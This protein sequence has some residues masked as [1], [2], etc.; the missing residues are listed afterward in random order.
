MR[1]SVVI[2]TCLVAASVAFAAEGG[3]VRIPRVDRP[4][5]LSDFIEGRAR[6]AEAVVSDFRQMMPGDG[7]PATQQTTAYLSYDDDNLYVAFYCKDDPAL[8]R[9]RYAK[10]DQ[11]MTDDRITFALDTFHDHHRAY[12]FDVN[13]F[14]IQADGNVTDGVEDDPSWDTIW[15]AEGKMTADGYVTL[16]AIPFKSLRFP[17]AEEQTWG[18]ILGRWINRNNEFSL[19]PTISRS[20]PGWVQQGGDLEGIRKISSGRN[21]QVIPYGSLRSSKSLDT[22]AGRFDRSREFR[23]GMDGKAVIKDAFTL[24]VALNPDFSQ[25]ESD[26]P[27]VTVNQ[28]YEVFFP[29]KRPFFLENAGFFKTPQTLLFSRRIADPEFGARLTGKVGRWAIGLLAADDRAPG[30]RVAPEDELHGEKAM[31]GVLRIQ[32][33]FLRD[34]GAAVMVTSQDFG[35]THNRVASFDTRLRVLPNWI[36]TG[37]AMTSSTRLRDGTRL[38]GPAYYSEFAHSGLHFVSSTTY[39]DRSPQFRADLGFINRVDM[40]EAAHT[41]GYIWRPEGKAIVSFGPR[42]KGS[43]NYDRLGRLQDWSVSP[44]FDLE[45]PRFTTIK[46]NQW[47]GFELFADQGFRKRHTEITF[48]SDWQRWLALTGEFQ[49]GTAVNYYP[50]AGLRPSIA[51]STGAQAGFTLRPNAHWKLDETYLYSELATPSDGIFNNHIIRSKANYQFNKAASLRAILDYN[52]VLP[53]AALVN[54]DREKHVGAD[55]LLTYML[56]PGTALYVGYT[57][58]FDNLRLDPMVS[59][60]LKRTAFPDLNTG[61]QVFVKLSYLFRF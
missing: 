7:V 29:E 22:A 3:V 32:R 57:D 39:T 12:W 14:G 42:V 52:A 53:N 46:L 20:R 2:V 40:R 47:E 6:E 51:N 27:Q 30:E 35:P 56:N 33:E 10:H 36:L 49:R 60:V 59:P 58:L 13:P 16:A 19:W 25:V 50:A 5:K 8:V 11:I 21:L 4:P 31:A 44:E 34:S 1:S 48:A 28:R 41:V 23:G 24:D 17:D 54:L 37:Q 18:L 43:I 38:S 9:A 26:E 55:V 61:R 15:H 45:L